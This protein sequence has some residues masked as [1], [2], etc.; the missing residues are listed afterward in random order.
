MEYWKKK[1]RKVEKINK[2]IKKKCRGK[3]SNYCES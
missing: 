1:I 2:F 3:N